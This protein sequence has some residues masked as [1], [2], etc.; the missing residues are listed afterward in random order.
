MS[1]SRKRNDILFFALCVL[2]PLLLYMVF[3][4]YPTLNT[5]WLSLFEY[6]GIGGAMTFVGLENFA[7]I[8]KDEHLLKSFGNNLILMLFVPFPTLII[9]LGSAAALSRK[10]LKERNFYR[11][12]F[13]FPSIL[14]FVVV[15]IVWYFIY[16]PNSGLLNNCL[17]ALGLKAL[18]LPW[19]GDSRTALGAIIVVLIWQAFGYYMVMYI[20]GID[21]IP[22]ELYEAA[23]VD[24]A[25]PFKQF[26]KITI[27]LLW[28]VIRITL[29]FMIGGTITISFLVANVL[30][31]GGPNFATDTALNQMYRQGT[32]NANYGY[33]MAI[34]VVVFLFSMILSMISNRLTNREE[35]THG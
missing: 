23:E 14:S 10:D 6:S 27:P 1:L 30:T 2:P 18:A 33:A 24:G 34:A 7:Y 12:V 9:A 22:Q 26:Y 28:P 31:A 3:Y 21:S 35:K 29:V 25:S 4:I 16:S 11:T 19:L 13:F 15:A 5:F 17:N 32:I 8:L 20:A